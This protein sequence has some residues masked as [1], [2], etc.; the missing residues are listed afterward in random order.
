M[1]QR[2]IM[3]SYNNFLLSVKNFEDFFFLFIWLALV[4]R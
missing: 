2:F 1:K 3:F 4:G